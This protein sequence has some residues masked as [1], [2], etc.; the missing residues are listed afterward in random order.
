[1]TSDSQIAACLRG[2]RHAQRELFGA[3]AP[4]AFRVASRYV[5]RRACVE[6]VVQEAMARV[7]SKLSDFDADRGPIEAWAHRIFVNESLRYLRR[8]GRLGVDTGQVPPT[9]P[10]SDKEPLAHQRLAAAEVRRLILAL[11][12]GYRAVFNL[13][14]VEGYTHVEIAAAL[15]ITAAT[16]RSQLTRAK[17]LLRQRIRAAHALPHPKTAVL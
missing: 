4:R 11:P 7:F 16:S 12:E 8:H 17:A 1:M 10:T 6:D 2:D 9:M 13:H 3:L 5:E 14:E 15:G